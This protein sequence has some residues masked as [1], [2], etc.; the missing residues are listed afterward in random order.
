MPA[1]GDKPHGRQAERAGERPDAAAGR[2]SLALDRFF[3]G[4]N[5]R[6]AV[7]PHQRQQLGAR[8]RPGDLLHAQAG[9]WAHRTGHEAGD[10][11][12]E[13]L[14]SFETLARPLRALVE[15]SCFD[16]AANP[17]PF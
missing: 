4:L 7:D 14:R 12:H 10:L 3:H 9:H 11:A 2:P 1:R 16:V 13:D 15:L 6:G 17:R 5:D 8:P